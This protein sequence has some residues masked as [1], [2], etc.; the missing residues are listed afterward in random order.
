MTNDSI[1]ALGELIL[2]LTDAH[3]NVKVQKAHN[4]VVATGLSFITSRMLGV[5]LVPV[6][7][8]AI[9]TDST[10]PVK[11]QTTLVAEAGRAVLTSATQVTRATS[12]DSVQYTATFA[13]GVGTGAIVEAGLFNDATAG[14]MV[15]R[16]IFAVINKG[17][18]DTLAITWKITVM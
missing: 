12:N 2:T 13:A 9:G 10:A 8:V 4:L 1:N 16:T 6:S 14:T 3:G 18:D 17:P 7:H 5:D 15:S 11:P